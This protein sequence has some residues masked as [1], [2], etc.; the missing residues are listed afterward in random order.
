MTKTSLVLVFCELLKLFEMRI[1]ARAFDRLSRVTINGAKKSSQKF[2][3]MNG[4]SMTVS[5][6]VTSQ[7]GTIKEYRVLIQRL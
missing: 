2:T 4:Q 6:V 5:V 3:L 1:Y 7:A